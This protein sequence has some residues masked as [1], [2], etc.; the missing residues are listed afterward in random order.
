MEKLE[1]LFAEE[2]INLPRDFTYLQDYYEYTE[3]YKINFLTYTI[4]GR[5][6]QYYKILV[7]KRNP[8]DIQ[9]VL[10]IYSMRATRKKLN[11]QL[12]IT[13]IE[14]RRMSA[15]LQGPIVNNE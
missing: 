12:V 13:V 5:A 8:G 11:S 15:Y 9:K 2:K 10:S 4:L 14:I 6:K 3:K 1:G 7:E